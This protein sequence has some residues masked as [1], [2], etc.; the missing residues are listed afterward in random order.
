MEYTTGVQDFRL[1][2]V[3][4]MSRLHPFLERGVL[5]SVWP[6]LVSTVINPPF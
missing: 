5:G 2:L 1:R 6:A 4:A 3:S